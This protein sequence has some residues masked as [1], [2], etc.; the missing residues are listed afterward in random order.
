M[1]MYPSVIPTLQAKR[2]DLLNKI[3]EAQN[4]ITRCERAYESLCEF[5]TIVVQSQE[6]FHEINSSK[7]GCLSGI[8]TIK[9]N[10]KV[11]Q[12]Y[13]AGIHNIITGI[14]SKIIGGV[15]VTLIVSISAK[16]RS[17]SNAVNEYE[18][19]ID[20]YESMIKNIDRQIDA[21][22]KAEALAQATLGGV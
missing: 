10:S 21:A 6:D 11:A 15:Y 20:S 12:R 22:R 14:G 8:E 3:S 16:L 18:D 5:K 2:R 1:G 9:M 17:Y 4:Q 7:I 13:Y 19:K